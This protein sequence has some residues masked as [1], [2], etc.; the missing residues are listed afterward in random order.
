MAVDENVNVAG[1]DVAQDAGV[2]RDEHDAA[3]GLTVDAVD[4]LRHD[5]Q[6]VDVEAG[7]GLV[8][9]SER[10]LQ[11]LHLEDLEALLLAA[12]ETDVDVTLGEVGVHAQVL[13]GGLHFL[14]PRAQGGRLAV[15]RGLRGAQ[16]VRDGDAG[17]L[18][19]VLHGKEQARL[20]ALI[21]AHLCDELIVEPCLTRGDLVVRVT[22]QGI[23]HG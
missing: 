11:K 5:A 16:E 21:D 6:C 20:G 4:A 8:E 15:D 7:V 23:G 10:G 1:L 3:A 14:D 13:H 2:V 12:G 22:G 19:G 17:D 9:D 18:D